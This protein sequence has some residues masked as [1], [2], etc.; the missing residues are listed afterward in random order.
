MTTIRRQA[1][2]PYTPEQMF[3]LVDDVESYPEFLTWCEEGEILNC[4]DDEMHA[5]LHLSFGGMRHAFTTCNR[6]QINKMIEIRLLDG[7]FRHME[8]FWRFDPISDNGCTVH[9]DLEFEF[10]NPLLS[11]TMGPIF[12]PIAE[13]LVGAFHERAEVVYGK[14]I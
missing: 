6:R 14:K 3:T 13:S 8:G 11:F 9:F 10:L 2:V 5:R 1:E 12:I 4:E 7:P